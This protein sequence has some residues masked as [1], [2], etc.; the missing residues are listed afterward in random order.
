[1]MSR[2]SVQD[3]TTAVLEYTRKKISR[4]E[5]EVSDSGEPTRKR[6]RRRRV[7]EHQQAEGVADINKSCQ[8]LE[9]AGLKESKE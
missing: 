3:E 5:L 6:R 4:D 7:M 1:M 9:R 2:A 8:W